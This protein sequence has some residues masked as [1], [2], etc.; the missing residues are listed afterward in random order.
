[1]GEGR[2]TKRG[3]ARFE[4][5]RSIRV[6]G[7][8][9]HNLQ[10]VDV[11][12]PRDV[13]TVITGVS[14]SG[15]SSLA[16]DTIFAEGQR[17]YME[18]LSAY[19]RQ[20]LDQLRKPDVDQIDG[21]TPTIAIEQ[22]AA[23]RNPRSTVA[24]TTEV[25]DYLRLLFARAGEPTCWA[26]VDEGRCGLPISRANPTSIHDAV[27]SMAEGTRLM[28]LAPV[29]RGKKGHHKEALEG[30]LKDG[31]V[32]ARVDGAVVDLS[33]AL[34]EPTDPDNP[35]GLGRYERHDIEVVVD[36]LDVHVLVGEL[37]RLR[38]QRVPEQRPVPRRRLHRLIDLG[39]P[40]IVRPVR[41][42]QRVRRQRLPQ[43]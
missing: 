3:E 42:Q 2:V 24:T 10:G 41:L 33:E 7:A 39:Q 25:Y 17:K 30:L 5:I 15:K 35:L 13:L 28:V 9:E 14:G 43:L 34:T 40:A 32:R 20:F 23:G 12:I 19:A 31:Y 4:P 26:E 38:A 22:R 21:L 1:M 11:D 29:V 8:R 36:R 6:R 16:F 27:T 37:D 18:S